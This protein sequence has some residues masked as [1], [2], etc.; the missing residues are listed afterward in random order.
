M[1]RL[2]LLAAL[3]MASRLAALEV[4]PLVHLSLNGGYAGVQNGQATALMLGE[5][6]A[7]PALQFSESSTLTPSLY[8]VGGGQQRALEE[9]TLFA[10]TG[11]LG[12]RPQWKISG[13]DGSAWLLRAEARRAYNVEAVNES[14]GS[15]RY[16]YEDFS[17]GAGWEGGKSFIPL[18]L[19]LDASHRDYPNY[20]NLSA[21][22][23]QYKNYYIKDFYGYRGEVHMDAAP[24]GRLGGSVQ[25]RQY[26]DSYVVNPDSGLVDTS[27][28]QHDLLYDLGLH[29][30][31]PMA[32]DGRLALGWNLMWQGSAS[33]QSTLTPPR[34]RSS[35]TAR[36]T[37]LSFWG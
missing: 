34:P 11:V 26:T 29:G 19:N 16:D 36:T 31:R 6:F 21:E 28:P 30:E 17:L 1:T 23:T 9:G 33:N 12:F 2:F 27:T 20:H 13:G 24:F 3:A 4:Q 7:V 25:W 10:R 22:Q 37:Q 8:L 32:M 35:E 5:F 14:Y 18:G 15:G